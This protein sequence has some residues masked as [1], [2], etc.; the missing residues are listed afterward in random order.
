[1]P[2][3]EAQTF[4]ITFNPGYGDLYDIMPLTTFKD[5]LMSKVKC[6]KYAIVGEVATFP[7]YHAAV[8]TECG[9][10]QDKIKDRLVPVFKKFMEGNGFTWEDK[11][12]KVAIKVNYHPDINC[13][14]GGYC[15]KDMAGGFEQ[16]G[17][18]EEELNSG[19]D[20]Y[21]NLLDEKKKKMPVSRSGLLPLMKEVF[22]KLW[23][24]IAIDTK[25]SQIFS[26]FSLDK[27]MDLL[28]SL[29]LA[30]GYDTS[31]VYGTLQ[32]KAITKNFDTIFFEHNA[33]FI[34]MDF[35]GKENL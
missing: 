32:W 3:K 34:L 15:T 5:L 30:D 6:K 28:N 14:A 21:D 23:Q 9:E 20:K 26:E 33:E 24:S 12:D 27:K 19:K 17:F 4:N 18:T 10:R 25:K 35:F 13:L 29:I 2:A 11:H 31:L 22:S 16:D 1:M 8:Y 7:H